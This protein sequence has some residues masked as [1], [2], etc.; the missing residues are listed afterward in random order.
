V[1]PST[2]TLFTRFVANAFDDDDWRDWEFPFKMKRVGT[3]V[4]KGMNQFGAP[5]ENTITFPAPRPD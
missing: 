2:E 1:K 4:L 5:V 3:V